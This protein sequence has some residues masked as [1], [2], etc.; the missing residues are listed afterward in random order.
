[1]SD[2]YLLTDDLTSGRYDLTVSPAWRMPGL[3]CASCGRWTANGHLR[4]DLPVPDSVREIRPVPVPLDQHLALASE[5]GEARLSPG[6][7]IGPLSGKVEN[8]SGVLPDILWQGNAIPLFKT[9]VLRNLSKLDLPPFYGCA[10][11]DVDE[12][13]ECPQLPHT[14]E[15][16][17]QSFESAEPECDAC[18]R[19]PAVLGKALS[20]V[21]GPEKAWP[22]FRLKD[23]PSQVV[24]SAALV[25]ALKSFGVTGISSVALGYE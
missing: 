21:R 6:T 22:M 3:Q 24:A 16:S 11:D 18:G 14:A 4:L 15:L 8:V 1:M 20:L 7:W 12:L 13:Y 17:D 10:L 2:F 9:S 19:K 5:L 23:A 25:S